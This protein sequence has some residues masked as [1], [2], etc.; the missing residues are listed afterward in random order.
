MKTK[1]RTGF[2]GKPREHKK[3]VCGKEAEEKWS[4]EDAEKV[5]WTVEGKRL[6]KCPKCSVAVRMSEA[7]FRETGGKYR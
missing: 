7:V 6:W 4:Q 2:G 3:C 1:Q 5:G